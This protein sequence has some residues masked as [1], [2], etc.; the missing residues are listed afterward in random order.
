MMKCEG[1][2]ENFKLQ[3]GDYHLKTNMFAIEMGSSNIML[4]AEWI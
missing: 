4:G 1:C 3:M 2:C